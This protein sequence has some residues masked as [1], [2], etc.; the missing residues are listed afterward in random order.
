MAIN[1]PLWNWFLKRSTPIQLK[2][3]V[4]LKLLWFNLISPIFYPQMCFAPTFLFS[5]RVCLHCPFLKKPSSFWDK[6]DQRQLFSGSIERSPPP[7]VG[8]VPWD[9]VSPSLTCFHPLHSNAFCVKISLPSQWG[10]SKRSEQCC[11]LQWSCF[12]PGVSHWIVLIWDW[13]LNQDSD[14]LHC[15]LTFSEGVK[16]QQYVALDEALPPGAGIK[17][18]AVDAHHH[19]HLHQAHLHLLPLHHKIH[20][21][22]G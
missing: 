18:D 8:L 12:T 3:F 19:L 2:E 15:R 11:Q 16:H 21:P 13:V 4:S 5:S 9:F 14:C 20:L 6:D 10:D 22:T 17:Q 1:P 7:G